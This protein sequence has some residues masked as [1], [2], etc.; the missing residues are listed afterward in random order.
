MRFPIKTEVKSAKWQ[1]IQK[2]IKRYQYAEFF[3]IQFFQGN[4]G[5]SERF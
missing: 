5:L 2:V 1:F 3:S 4:K